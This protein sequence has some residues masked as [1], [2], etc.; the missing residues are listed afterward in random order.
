MA[1]RRDSNSVPLPPI[2]WWAFQPESLV[3]WGALV[4]LV[5]AIAFQVACTAPLP[6]PGN[7]SHTPHHTPLEDYLHDAELTWAP[8]VVGS[9]AFTF[10]SYAYL[11]EA[12]HAY[13]PLCTPPDGFTLGY[14]VCVGNLLGSSL[15]TV[16]S[17]CYFVRETPA[18]PFAPPSNG[19]H[20]AA[21]P[22]SPPP[23][24]AP[25]WEFEVSEWAVRFTY[26][27]GSACFLVAAL[28]SLVEVINEAD[29]VTI[30]RQASS[31]HH[32]HTGGAT[33]GAADAPS[34]TRR[35][36]AHSGA[37][38]KA[39][40]NDDSPRLEQGEADRAVPAVGAE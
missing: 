38:A 31:Y 23:P 19:T 6:L 3:Y 24:P 9:L 7:H 27:I 35:A 28:A 37:S 39:G 20:P 29:P 13:N 1:A 18:R 21:A 22:P 33:G 32:Q 4:Q 30:L 40:S 14:G 36:H 11:V 17:L 34:G 25:L 16:A 10:A 8:S 12:T 5:G 15:F 26:A 2:R